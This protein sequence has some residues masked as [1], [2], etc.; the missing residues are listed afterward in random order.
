MATL[1]CSVRQEGTEQSQL[2][3][4]VKLFRYSVYILL[5]RHGLQA[6]REALCSHK[7]ARHIALHLLAPGTKRYLPAHAAAMLSPPPA[8][9]PAAAGTPAAAAVGSKPAEDDEEKD[10]D[11]DMVGCIICA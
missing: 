4:Y 2:Q 1:S 5:S 11:D 7:A 10:D 6:A 3:A 9:A 8:P